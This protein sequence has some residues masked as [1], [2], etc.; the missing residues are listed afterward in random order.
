MGPDL[1]LRL[2][3]YELRRSNR[4]FHFNLFRKYYGNR[5]LPLPAVHCTPLVHVVVATRL[6][7]GGQSK[8]LHVRGSRTAARIR[9]SDRG[10]DCPVLDTSRLKWPSFPSG[11]P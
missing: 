8:S 3:S 6:P 11:G 9:L 7:C 10:L 5:R 4:P 1:L 2:R